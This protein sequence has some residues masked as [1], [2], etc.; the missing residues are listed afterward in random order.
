LITGASSGLGAALARRYAA[1]GWAIS[2]FGRDAGRLEMTAV[3]CRPNAAWV[4]VYHCDLRHADEAAR[5][6]M[7]AEGV[8][9]VD[10]LIANA[11]LGGSQA[12]ASPAGETNEQSRMLVETNLTALINS[13]APLL[14]PMIARRS[15]HIVIM[16][17]IAGLLALPHSPV[18]C[19]TKSAAHAYGDGLRRLLRPSGVAVSVI[20]PGF[21]E[22]PMS[23]SLAMARPF[24]WT[25]DRAA[26]HIAAAVDKRRRRV[27]FPWPLRWAVAL[28]RL[29]PPGWLDRLLEA[30]SNGVKS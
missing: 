21:V 7:A 26:A 10:L 8:A 1:S 9:P 16:G 6:L 3:A 11:G 25:A 28:A 5:S 17:S 30:P 2:L 20:C 18:Y 24:L 12:L 22:T 4:E 14:A 13:V 15:G 27:V 23:A 29:A 19:A